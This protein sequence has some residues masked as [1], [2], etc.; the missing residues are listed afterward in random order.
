M[1]RGVYMKKKVLFVM[2]GLV[3]LLVTGCGNKM[4]VTKCTLTN[5]NKTSGYKLEAVY[6]IYAK[7]DEVQK[8]E[9]TEIVTSS[10]SSVL[11][12]FESYINKTYKTYNDS[13]GGYT[14]NV[15]NSD[16][17]VTSKVTIDY[18]K[19][20][21]KQFVK[22]NSSMKSYVDSNNMITTDG[23]KTLYEKLGASCQK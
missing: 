11:S 23:M 6:K 14:Y 12:Y 21:I 22:D 7:N 5:D 13:Y 3:L 1:V 18:N 15:T 16:G 2:L 10:N 8:V 19:L 20:N 9:T 17:K 4:E